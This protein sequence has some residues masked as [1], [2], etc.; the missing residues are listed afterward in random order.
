M[1]SQSVRANS[2][3][4]MGLFVIIVGAAITN[5]SVTGGQVMAGEKKLSG[6]FHGF[7]GPDSVTD[8]FL[9]WSLVLLC[10]RFFHGNVRLITAME[11]AH[12]TDAVAAHARPG[13]IGR[14][15]RRLR[16]IAAAGAQA[17]EFLVIILQGAALTSFGFLLTKPQLLFFGLLFLLLTDAA[18][19]IIQYV[20]AGT[21][22]PHRQ[23]WFVFNLVTILLLCFQWIFF[24]PFSLT[25]SSMMVVMFVVD[26][27]TC[28]DF[29]F[30]PDGES[31]GAR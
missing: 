18:L 11:S 19:F 24:L 6:V 3:A 12:K 31:A 7:T 8:T 13:I 2:E 29:Y 27:L 23:S 20:S 1:K 30:P 26:Y 22:E 5:L 21:A 25:I 16:R 9:A 17:G 15:M 14:L 28:W 10:V 4:L